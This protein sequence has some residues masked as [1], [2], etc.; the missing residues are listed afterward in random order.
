[1]PKPVVIVVKVNGEPAR[2]LIDSG[3]LGDF[4]SSTLVQQLGL[5]RKELTSPVPVQLAVQGSRSRINFGTTAPFKYQNINETCYFD[6]INLSG[7]D[8]ILG[9]PWLYQHRV[10]FG[11][12]PSRVVIGSAILLPMSGEGVTCL[13]SRS[14][15]LYQENLE[16]IHKELREYAQPICKKASETPLPPLQAINHEIPLINPDLVYPWHPARCP[17]AMC[18]QWAKKRDAYI[19]SGRWEVT[20]NGNAMTMLLI[21]KPGKPG[22]PQKLRTAVD[23]CPRNA[24]TVKRRHCRILMASCGVWRM[25]NTNQF[26][27]QDAYE[28]IHLNM[29]IVLLSLHLMV[30]W[31]VM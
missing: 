23:T 28:Q 17:E 19:K 9:T 26:D 24:N 13:A 25:V 30:I 22:E 20:S 31:L 5:K 29:F 2:A 12:N 6:V 1:I 10:T 27:S 11:I 3:S 8:L 4:I 15:A 16:C 14:M 7:Y 21:P 18:A